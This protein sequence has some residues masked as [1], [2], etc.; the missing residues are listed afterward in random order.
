MKKIYLLGRGSFD[1]FRDFI[2]ESVVVDQMRLEMT[3]DLVGC[4]ESRKGK[5]AVS[6]WRHVGRSF[7]VGEVADDCVLSKNNMR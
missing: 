4:L 6:V 2:I 7:V 3:V 5:A 1:G